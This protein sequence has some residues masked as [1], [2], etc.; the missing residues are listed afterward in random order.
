VQAALWRRRTPSSRF[1]DTYA[2]R[3]SRLHDSV[4][5]ETSIATNDKPAFNHVTAYDTTAFCPAFRSPR[6][7]FVCAGIGVRAA[8]AA[9]ATT[10]D[11]PPPPVPMIVAGSGSARVRVEA[12]MIMSFA[13]GSS[14]P[15]FF[16]RP[17][18]LA[19]A[20]APV[21]RVPLTI[22]DEQGAVLL[23]TAALTVRIDRR[24]LEFD[25]LS[26][27]DNTPVLARARVAAKADGAGWTLLH[28]VDNDEALFGLGEDNENSGRLNRRGTIRDLW[29]GQ[30]IKSGNV[31]A[32][33]PIPLC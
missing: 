5:L 32:Q 11:L 7:L 24:T 6:L 25:V 23:S 15:R 21:P 13:S 16:S 18:S 33:Y 30:K 12:L 1:R 3:A 19:L 8:A 31:T 29:A 27:S 22:R 10:S 4:G 17:Q 14:L 28:Q 20:E 2:T 26:N 9:D